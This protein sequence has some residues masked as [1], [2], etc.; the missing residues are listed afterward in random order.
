MEA[1][2]IK[3]SPPDEVQ[4][5]RNECVHGVATLVEADVVALCL[6]AFNHIK[7]A[8]PVHGIVRVTG[9]GNESD[10]LLFQVHRSGSLLFPQIAGIT[11]SFLTL[12]LDAKTE[13]KT[14]PSGVRE[15]L[16]IL[17]TILDGKIP[18]LIY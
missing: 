13:G 3:I 5:E 15:G 1:L 11:L 2:I 18:I 12:D 4:A 17:K 14:H 9:A 7:T 10:L 16:R 6:Q 8:H